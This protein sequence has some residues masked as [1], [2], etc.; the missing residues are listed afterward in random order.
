MAKLI[1]DHAAFDRFIRNELAPKFKDA[2]EAGI[3]ILQDA[4]PIDTGRLF[5]S[6]R[7][8]DP[9]VK[10][11]RIETAIVL[12]GI[13]LP[14]VFKE[15]TFKRAIDYVMSVEIRSP[16]IRPIIPEVEDSI[17]QKMRRKR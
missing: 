11:K 13:E 5:F 12:G 8:E 14:G 2:C 4:A 3:G 1:V 7:I 10:N 17:V 6:I 15:Q 9:E 16:F